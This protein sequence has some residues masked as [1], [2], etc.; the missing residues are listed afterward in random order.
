MLIIPPGTGKADDISWH[1][2]VKIFS[3]W[4]NEG[5]GGGFVG[6]LYLD[7]HPRLGKY[8]PRL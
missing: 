7:L 3:V 2:D 5:E 8:S 6:Y 1:K 4:D